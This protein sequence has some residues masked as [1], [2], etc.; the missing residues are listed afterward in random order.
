MFCGIDEAFENN[1]LGS[2]LQKFEEQYKQ[3]LIESVNKEQRIYNNYIDNN[4]YADNH[5]FFTA[6][7]DINNNS[8]KNKA[9]YGFDLMGTSIYDL[10]KNKPDESSIV[11]LFD[12]SVFSS[13]D[14]STISFS[15]DIKS[16]DIKSNDIKSNDFKSMGS[17]IGSS[18]SFKDRTHEYYIR[19]FIDDF[20]N[21]K[22]MTKTDYDDTYGHIKTCKYCKDEIKLRM[23]GKIE[24]V[25]NHEK[26]YIIPKNNIRNDIKEIIVVVL[27]GIVIIFLLDLFSKINK[28]LKKNSNR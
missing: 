17:E 19:S 8:I 6:Q 16:N 12:D 22:S 24:K 14:A 11:S 3:S 28:T 25:I 2:Q 20:N 7:G 4:I 1:P 10:K 9:D 13:D 18:Y 27:I 15:G 23:N 26:K 5:S 21:T